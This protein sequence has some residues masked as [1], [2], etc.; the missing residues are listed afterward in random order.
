MPT[1]AATVATPASWSVRRLA[2]EEVTPA[3]VQAWAALE[4][5]ALEPNACASPYF[6]L[7]AAR[8]LAGAGEQPFVE[9]VE[10]RS[11]GQETVRGAFALRSRMATRAM[12]LPHLE[13]F[14]TLHTFFGSPLVDRDHGEAVWQALFDAI[15]SRHRNAHALVLRD[16]ERGGALH[17][18]LQQAC[19]RYGARLH[20]GRPRARAVLRREHMGLAA[21]KTALRK[22]HSEIERCRRRL[23]E[24]GTLE[25]RVLRES[26]PEAAVDDFIRLEHAGWKGEEG[27]SLHAKPHEEAFF[28]EMSTG[29]ASAGRALFTELKLDGQTIASTSNFVSGGMGFAFKVGWD[30]AWRKLGVGILN[31]AELVRL[32]PEVCADIECFDSGSEPDSFIEKLWPGRRELVT[33]VVCFDV[34]ARMALHGLRRAEQLHRKLKTLRKRSKDDGP[35]TT[36]PGA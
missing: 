25:W 34:L 16:I 33:A 5:R 19:N 29:F 36:L 14:H 6:V 15:A 7:P 27:S 18:G 17:Q 20:L 26:L 22:Q 12:P 9:L 21:L 4:A 8:H 35:A 1:T 28:R 24:A 10:S 30:P 31:E 13:A 2:M 3:D 32:A 23:A 11:E